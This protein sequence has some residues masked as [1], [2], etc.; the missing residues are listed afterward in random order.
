MQVPSGMTRATFFG[1][2]LTILLGAAAACGGDAVTFPGGTGGSGTGSGAGTGTGSGAGGEGGALGS[3]ECDAPYQPVCGE[4]GTTYDAACGPE[5]VPVAI[6]CQ[7][8]CPCDPCAAL[9]TQYAAALEEAKS[10]DPTIDVEQ[11]TERIADQLACP[12]PTS[13]APVNASAMTTLLT[14]ATEW[15]TLGCG[16]NV[17]CPDVECPEIQGAFCAPST[18][19]GGEGS[20]QEQF[21]NGSAP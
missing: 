4:D 14:L 7:G 19:S 5:C 13:V 12:C 17:A 6:A 16:Q 3:C 10:C 8:E 9:E 15:D 1:S 20:C 18:S 21:G 11:C 2:A